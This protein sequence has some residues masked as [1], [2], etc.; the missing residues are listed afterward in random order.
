MISVGFCVF[1]FVVLYSLDIISDNVSNSNQDVSSVSWQLVLSA[2]P[3]ILIEL[4]FRHLL[5]AWPFN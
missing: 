3:A 5:K 4:G 1:F 2:I